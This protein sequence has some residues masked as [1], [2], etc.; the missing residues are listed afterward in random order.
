[1]VN[2]TIVPTLTLSSITVP[3]S[4]PGSSY[5][6]RLNQLDLRFSKTIRYRT[7]RIQPQVGI[8]NVTNAD[9][10][11]SQTAVFGPALGRIGKVLDGRLVK[12]GAQIDF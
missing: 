8:F 10:T 9:T 3:L 1:V 12:I 11:L 5:Y 6:P 7:T 4:E 2:R